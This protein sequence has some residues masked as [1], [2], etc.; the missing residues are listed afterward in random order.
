MTT[1][2]TLSEIEIKWRAS[3]SGV[4]ILV[5]GETE[6]ED[7]WFYN[8][9]FGDRAREITFFPQ[10]G[11]GKVVQAV[12][13]LRPRLGARRVYGIVDRD[14]EEQSDYPPVPDNGVLCTPRY[15]LENYLLDAGCWFKYIEPHTLRM[16]KPGWNSPEQAQATI[17]GLYRECLPLSAFNW[18]LRQAR[19]RS[20]AAFQGLREADREYKEHPRAL[21]NLGDVTA[22][23]RSIRAQM[24]LPDD[25]GLMYA[26]RMAALE[27]MPLASLEQVVSGKY[28]LSLLR[29]RFPLRLSGKE[30]WDD[31]LSAYIHGCPAPP[32]DL[33]NLVD[34]ILQDARP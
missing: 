8:T 6:L 34:L 32:A 1:Y 22:H 19:G 15:T 11:R 20:Y 9:W 4:C 31:V 12:A 26:G 5:E 27:G 28:V 16:P 17:E 33:V 25:L 13:E 7:A 23:L 24:G 10:D 29:E 3:G 30:A 14:F 21:E 18:T 2:P